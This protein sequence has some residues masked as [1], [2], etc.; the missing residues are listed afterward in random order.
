MQAE[1]TTN[2]VVW[3]ALFGYSSFEYFPKYDLDRHQPPS[4]SVGGASEGRACVRLHPETQI[5]Y[6]NFLRFEL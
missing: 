5:V 2:F 1:T 4:R 3:W 6:L